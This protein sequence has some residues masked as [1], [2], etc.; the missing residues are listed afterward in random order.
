MYHCLAV[1]SQALSSLWHVEL[2]NP[3]TP[4]ATDPQVG[5]LKAALIPPTRVAAKPFPHG[6]D[7]EPFMSFGVQDLSH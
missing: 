2:Y 3:V 6:K 7:L 1:I 4:E 5:Q